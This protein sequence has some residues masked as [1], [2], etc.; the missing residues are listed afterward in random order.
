[1]GKKKGRRQ[2]R[3]ASKKPDR[4]GDEY[5]QARR[6][7]EVKAAA[8]AQAVRPQKFS[9]IPRYEIKTDLTIQKLQAFFTRRRGHFNDVRSTARGTVPVTPPHP[10]K[11]DSSDDDDSDDGDEDGVENIITYHIV[12]FISV[13]GTLES[14]VTDY[15]GYVVAFRPQPEEEDD[16]S[17]W[18]Y[19]EVVELPAHLFGQDNMKLT[20]GSGYTSQ[21]A[22]EVGDGFLDRMVEVLLGFNQQNFEEQSNERL[23][24]IET[25]MVFLGEAQRLP[26]ILRFVIIN[27]KAQPWVALGSILAMWTNNWSKGGNAT[28]HV[29]LALLAKELLKDLESKKVSESKKDALKRETGLRFVKAKNFLS[30]FGAEKVPLTQEELLRSI[31][32]RFLD[33]MPACFLGGMWRMP[34]G[35]VDGKIPEEPVFGAN[36][37]KNT[38]SLPLLISYFQLMKYEVNLVPQLIMRQDGYKEAHEANDAIGFRWVGN[39]PQLGWNS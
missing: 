30:K 19:F 11:V 4:D 33:L 37:P 26:I 27:F 35:L 22:V 25:L 14:L 31:P 32:E 39:A 29:M 21:E 17:G 24:M 36:E 38:Y 7:A 20:Y 28:L 9:D 3:A 12:V 5:S 6:R 10:K 34:E 16:N 23:R 15:D 2:H 18:F 1:M 13:N 8:K